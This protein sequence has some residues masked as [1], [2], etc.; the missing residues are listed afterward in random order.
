MPESLDRISKRAL[1][2][3]SQPVKRCC[4]PWRENSASTQSLV[5]RSMVRFGEA[6]TRSLP[7]RSVSYRTRWPISIIEIHQPSLVVVENRATYQ[8]HTRR[9][10]L[11]HSLT[12]SSFTTW[13][14]NTRKDG[15]PMTSA[16]SILVQTNISVH[17]SH[18]ELQDYKNRL[19]RLLMSQG[20][21]TTYIRTLCPRWHAMGFKPYQIIVK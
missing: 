10:G 5:V 9:T 16:H 21:S 7:V 2:K 8:M 14:G 6:V 11:H 1:H 13:H 4:H 3:K 17:W 19:P 18:R 15:D 12:Q 20:R